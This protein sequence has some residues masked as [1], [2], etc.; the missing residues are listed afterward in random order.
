MYVLPELLVFLVLFHQ[1]TT[2]IIKNHF[3]LLL[4]LKSQ[5]LTAQ[6]KT[7]SPPA[8][9]YSDLRGPFQ[10]LQHK[11]KQNQ[12]QPFLGSDGVVVKIGIGK[13]KR[14]QDTGFPMET[15]NP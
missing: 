12:H 7:K 13:N 8:T 5:F 2:E 14:G 1:Q 15:K 9:L 4:S 6:K 11:R 10:S 3:L